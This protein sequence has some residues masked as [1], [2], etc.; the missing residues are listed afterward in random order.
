MAAPKSPD[1]KAEYIWFDGEFV[2]WEEAKVHVLTHALHYGSSVFEGIRCYETPEGPKVFRLHE[3]IHRLFFSARVARMDLGFQEEEIREACLE[4]IRQ[5]GFDSCYIRPL[6]FRG[7][8]SMGILP[9]DCPIHVVVATW[10]W[11]AYLGV[12]ALE[13]GIDAMISSWRK[14]PPGSIPALTKMGGA[15]CLATL[16]KMEASRAGYSEA[17][18]MDTEGRVAE[19]TGEN[20]FAVLDGQLITPPLSHS[21]LGGLTRKSVMQLA[22]DHGVKVVEQPLTRDFLYMSHE[23]FFTGTAAEITPIRS[24]DG[25]P[26]GSGSVGPITKRLQTDFFDIVN[27]RTK[28]RHGWLTLAASNESRATQP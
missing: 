28:D 10:A 21:V 14:M 1:P 25:L 9:R 12:D 24:V 2:R 16:A 8:G 26:I 15:Y 22:E 20:L 5:N 27:G 17:L 13:K 11:G 19:G 3:H 23:L 7:A 6:V 18:L 4:A